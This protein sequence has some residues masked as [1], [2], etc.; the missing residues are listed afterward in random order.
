MA[1]DSKASCHQVHQVADDT[2]SLDEEELH[3]AGSGG[4]D[5]KCRVFAGGKEV[6][7]QIDTGSSV[8]MLPHGLLNR[9][10][11]LTRY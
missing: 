5:L 8:S 6:T 3:T 4:R 7:F 1:T 11:Q 10:N 9:L 2:S